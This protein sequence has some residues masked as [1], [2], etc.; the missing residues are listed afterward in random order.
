MEKRSHLSDLLCVDGFIL[1]LVLLNNIG[2]LK[3]VLIL[4]ALLL[5]SPIDFNYYDQ[6]LLLIRFNLAPLESNS[7]ET[8]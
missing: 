3:M 4:L 1:I 8:Y 7:M 5:R 2:Q 6:L